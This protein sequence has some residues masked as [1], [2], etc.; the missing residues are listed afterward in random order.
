MP[1]PFATFCGYMYSLLRMLAER[2]RRM[3]SLPKST[4]KY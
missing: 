2:K 3:A 1:V 4:V